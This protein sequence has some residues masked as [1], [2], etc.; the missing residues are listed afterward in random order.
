LVN[1]VSE[2][3]SIRDLGYLHSF[4]LRNERNLLLDQIT[5]ILK[6]YNGIAEISFESGY[7]IE[8]RELKILKDFLL[9]IM[10]L[11][12]HLSIQIS[13]IEKEK[14]NSEQN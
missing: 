1:K 4:H 10:L 8:S 11:T 6:E 3:K 2:E 12:E 7:E 13:F 5:R 14:E 9:E